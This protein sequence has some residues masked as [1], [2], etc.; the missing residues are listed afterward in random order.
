M[1]SRGLTSPNFGTAKAMPE[2][3]SSW[4]VSSEG[5]T[6]MFTPIRDNATYFHDGSSVTAKDFE[7]TWQRM[8][9]PNDPDKSSRRV[10]R[11]ACW[12]RPTPT[13]SR[14]SAMA[15]SRSTW[16]GAD[17]VL[18]AAKAGVQAGAVLSWAVQIEKD[19]KKL[20]EKPIGAGPVQARH[21]HQRVR[22][23]PSRPTLWVAL[24]LDKI[25]FQ[26]ISDPTALATAWETGSVQAS[27]FVPLSEPPHHGQQGRCS[28]RASRM[29]RTSRS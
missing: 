9:N 12:A 19:G 25:I 4:D 22:T 8:F 15:A 7:R 28:S 3:A 17:A 6:Y 2:L 23:P 1:I 29:C 5:R 13:L 16:Y 10:P 18:P 20:G 11:A 21:L 24:L 26:V 14:C 27:V